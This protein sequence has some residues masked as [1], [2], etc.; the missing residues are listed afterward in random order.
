[1]SESESV[2][3][4]TCKWSLYIHFF[5]GNFQL[6]NCFDILCSIS[7]HDCAASDL[8][9]LCIVQPLY[10][11]ILLIGGQESNFGRPSWIY[12]DSRVISYSIKTKW[13]A[14][15]ISF[16]YLWYQ[17]LNICSISPQDS[18][19]RF[20]DTVR[21]VHFVVSAQRCNRPNRWPIW[22]FLHGSVDT[23]VEVLGL[24]LAAQ[25]VDDGTEQPTVHEER[26]KI[27]NW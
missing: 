17:Y 15:T 9:T 12:R 4:L 5:C 16:Q 27:Q 22:I 25:R 20:I 19:R 14:T 23:L 10:I 11:N 6:S 18:C 21:M 1:M 3:C 2:S 24:F 13:P 7:R 26:L 8:F